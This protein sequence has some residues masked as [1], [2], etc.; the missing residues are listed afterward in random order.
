MVTTVGL[1]TDFTSAL[2]G[3]IELDYDAIEAYGAAINRL[4]NAHYKSTLKEFKDDHQ[5]HINEI[6]KF[7]EVCNKVPPSGPSLK[8]VFTQGKVI[9]ANLVGDKA[10]LRAMR[11]NEIDTN[12]AYGRI[13]NYDNIPGEIK[14]IL[15]K[16]LLDEKK[17]LA[18]IE[19]TLELDNG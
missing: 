19:E 15:K 16:G 8:S 12:T 14:E 9:L 1:Q 6:S 7:F 11:S 5:R 10:I 17:H 2:K 18:W 3:L 4:E 13:N